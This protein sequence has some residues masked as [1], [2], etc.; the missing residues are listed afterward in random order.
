[1]SALS[2]EFESIILLGEE[3]L[4]TPAI[5]SEAEA[6]S[7][8]QKLD[9]YLGRVDSLEPRLKTAAPGSVPAET[10]QKLLAVHGAVTARTEN[11]KEL[12]RRKISLLHQRSTALRNYLD[13]LPGRI[14]ITGKREG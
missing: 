8:V 2:P 13:R 6:D 12:V 9:H 1:V 11:E 3:L 4:A 7:F 10:V 5:E 14:S